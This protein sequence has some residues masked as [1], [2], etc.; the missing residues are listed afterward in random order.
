MQRMVNC[1][2][3]A[4]DVYRAVSTVLGRERFWA[5]SAPESGGVISFVLADGRTD[6]SP[7]EQA[8]QDRL[9]QLRHFGQTLTFAL[10]PTPT[11]GTDLTLTLTTPADA[12]APT[13]TG[14]TDLT[15]TLTTPAD[16]IAPAAAGPSDASPTTADGE[17]DSGVLV[18][19]LLRLKAFVD[20]G[21]DLRNH[22][23]RRTT[24]YA[25]S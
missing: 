3:A 7:I 22:D 17:V 11:G 4:S 10:A 12:L 5:E 2:S 19:L 6:E 23:A 8:V 21:V 13:P 18:S 14:G 9:Y 16:A 15:L 20:F 24:A 1:A 25:D